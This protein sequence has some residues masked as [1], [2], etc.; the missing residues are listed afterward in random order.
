[1]SHTLGKPTTPPPW[2]RWALLGAVGLLL[3]PWLFDSH[4]AVALFSQMGI[5][6]IA[7]LSYNIL[8]GQGGML[9]FGHAVYTG[10]GTCLAIHALLAVGA[11]VLPVPVVLVPL[12]GG[13]A[14]GVFALLLGWI[15]TR[16]AG[17]TFGMISLGLGELVFAAALM[18]PGLFGGVEGISANRV[19]GPPVWGISLGPAV[20]VYY[21]IAVYTLV[22]VVLMYGLTRTPL[23]RLL[24][25]VRDNPERLA[26]IGY[27]PRTVR[28]LAFVAAGFFAGIAGGLAAIEFERVS[29]EV[30]SP[31]RSG[32]Y[33]LFT[34]L[35]GT[36]VFFGPIVG[37]V[38]MV[39][40]LVGLSQL[41]PAWL[42]YLGLVFV[43]MVM[44]APEGLAGL[45]LKQV[46]LLRGAGWRP[47]LGPYAALAFSVLVCSLGA[48]ALVEML[49]QRQLSATLGDAVSFLGMTLDA[50][51]AAV[52]LAAA[53]VLALGLGLLAG[54]RR[55]WL[56]RVAALG[57]AAAGV[58]GPLV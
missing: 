23:G 34:F 58:Q 6:V 31:V 26:F 5:A 29:P 55:L 45:W 27:N 50:G 22:C 51:R 10:L 40:A 24:N 35:G 48:G 46:R 53:A 13:L 14:G 8:L 28:Y 3:A 57:L 36:T 37:G 30:V 39:L 38:L 1:M 19:V 21:L 18:F 16:Q 4:R 43:L 20:Q 7:C 41:T 17:T 12:L 44:Y 33:L 54:A 47:L 25:A 49:Y 32:S 9:S 15:S 11:G 2:L 42:L 52:W 56:R